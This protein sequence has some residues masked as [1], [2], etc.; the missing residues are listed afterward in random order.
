MQEGGRLFAHGLRST[1]KKQVWIVRHGQAAHNPRAE[2]AKDA[3]CSH[4]EFLQ[5]MKDDDV[6]DAPTT[7][8]GKQQAQDLHEKHSWDHL[9]LIVSSPLSRALETCDII[10][11]PSS[12]GGTITPNRVCVEHFR[13]INGWLLNAKRRDRTVLQNTFPPWD[14]EGISESDELWT[15][16]LEEQVDCAHR[17]YEGLRWLLNRPESNILLVCHGGI[18]RFM[19]DLIPDTVHVAD[20]RIANDDKDRDVNARFGNCELRRYELTW[21]SNN[22]DCASEEEQKPVITLKEIDL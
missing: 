5:Y 16:H 10:V 13:E 15:S 7:D 20:G 3:G 19:M 1:M 17:G 4:D 12:D 21:D 6:L 2:A 9:D 8:L 22:T 14:F 18:L 11:P